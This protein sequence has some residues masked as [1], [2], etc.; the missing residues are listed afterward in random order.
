[1][2]VLVKFRAYCF[3]LGEKTLDRKRAGNN[4]KKGTVPFYVSA[5][6]RSLDFR[7][8]DKSVRFFVFLPSFPRRRES[9]LKASSSGWITVKPEQHRIIGMTD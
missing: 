7:E 3:A 6:F 5:G 8:I 2:T 4:Q 9:I 1:M